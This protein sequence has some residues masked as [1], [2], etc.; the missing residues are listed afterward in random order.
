[1]ITSN[2]ELIILS[3]REDFYNT[4]N[5]KLENDELGGLITVGVKCFYL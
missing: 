5:G 4:V 3:S 1:M 2:W